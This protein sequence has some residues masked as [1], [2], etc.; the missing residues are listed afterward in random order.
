MPFVRILCFSLL[1][2]SLNRFFSRFHFYFHFRFF[3]S[4]SPPC[5]LSNLLCDEKAYKM[6]KELKRFLCDSFRMCE[7]LVSLFRVVYGRGIVAWR[8]EEIR[9]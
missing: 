7:I 3:F 4:Y 6:K 2:L 8:S 1:F 5:L 9:C